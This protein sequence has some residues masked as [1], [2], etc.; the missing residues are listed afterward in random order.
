MLSSRAIPRGWHSHVLTDGRAR[1]FLGRFWAARNIFLG[2]ISRLEIFLWVHILRWTYFLVFWVNNGDQMNAFC[3]ELL[4]IKYFFGSLFYIENIILGP[5]FRSAPEPPRQNV[6]QV[7]PPRRRAVIQ[8]CLVRV[9]LLLG[10]N[11]CRNYS[12][13]LMGGLD[14]P[15]IAYTGRE[16]TITWFCQGFACLRFCRFKLNK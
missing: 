10:H 5:P 15:L 2:L 11:S 3:I 7:P 14:W 1:A 8:S 6:I 4:N 9:S 13:K 16:S 12:V